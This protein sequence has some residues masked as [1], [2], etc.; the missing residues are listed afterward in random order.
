MAIYVASY[1][2]HMQNLEKNMIV[3][4]SLVFNLGVFQPVPR[5]LLKGEW[6]WKTKLKM[7]PEQKLFYNSEFHHK[8]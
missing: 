4:E 3:P 7:E 5:L 6:I 1:S 8:C 2:L